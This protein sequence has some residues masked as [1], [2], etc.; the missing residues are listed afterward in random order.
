[1]NLE[2]IGNTSSV[3]YESTTPCADWLRPSNKISITHNHHGPCHTGTY[4]DGPI[5]QLP[6]KYSGLIAFIHAPARD[7]HDD[8]RFQGD[9][10]FIEVLVHR[11]NHLLSREARSLLLQFIKTPYPQIVT[12]PIPYDDYVIYAYFYF[13]L[14]QYVRLWA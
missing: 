5:H 6:P 14:L 8:D 7:A 3:A 13:A 9:I 11:D 1:M 4:I 12:P 2:T 10:M